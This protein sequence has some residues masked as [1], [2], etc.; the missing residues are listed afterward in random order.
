[1]SLP[2][3]SSRSRWLVCSVSEIWRIQFCVCAIQACVC[4]IQFCVCAIQFCVCAIQACVCAIDLFVT[5]FS[6]HAN[7]KSNLLIFAVILCNPFVNN[8]LCDCKIGHTSSVWKIILE[9]FNFHLGKT[10]NQRI[11]T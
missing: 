10:V 11:E 8:N 1:M 9:M 7:R 2:Q 4:A 5:Q 6:N 3:K